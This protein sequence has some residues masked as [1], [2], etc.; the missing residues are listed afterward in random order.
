[1]CCDW[2]L[3][4]CY[5]IPEILPWL[6]FSSF[7]LSFLAPLVHPSVYSQ[8]YPSFPFFSF[9][10]FFFLLLHSVPSPSSPLY[11][12]FHILRNFPDVHFAYIYGEQHFDLHMHSEMITSE[13]QINI[14]QLPFP[15]Y[16]TKAAKIHSVA[17]PVC[18]TMLTLIPKL[19][20]RTLEF[21][22]STNCNFLSPFPT[23]PSNCLPTDCLRLAL[24][25][26]STVGEILCCFLFYAGLVHL[27]Q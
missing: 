9:I 20:G 12:L 1:M 25:Q 16:R 15:V 13:K 24:V 2:V 27:P 5:N 14:F 6:Y 11:L 7:F 8:I 10:T 4:G 26:D 22:H 3:L 17:N 18:R 19:G 23:F 21:S